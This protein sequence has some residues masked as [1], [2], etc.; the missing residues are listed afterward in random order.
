MYLATYTYAP[1][2]SQMVV[3]TL[4]LDCHL[5]TFLFFLSLVRKGRKGTDREKK[6]QM[7]V[8][9]IINSVNTIVLQSHHMPDMQGHFGGFF[10]F[11]HSHDCKSNCGMCVPNCNNWNDITGDD[12]VSNLQTIKSDICADNNK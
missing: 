1:S 12:R 11:C 8:V 3:V 9:W 6:F 2:V 10:G 4:A 7:P 5:K